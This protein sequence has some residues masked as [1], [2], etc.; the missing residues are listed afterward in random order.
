M[1]GIAA[2]NGDIIREMT[3]AGLGISLLPDF[4]VEEDIESGR[5]AALFEDD[6]E[7]QVGIYTLLPARRQIT[8]AARAFADYIFDSLVS[9]SR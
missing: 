1:R 7:E 3:L 2:N 5:L 9:P 8:P 6:F 4:F